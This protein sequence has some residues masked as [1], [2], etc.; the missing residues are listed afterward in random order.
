MIITPSSQIVG[1]RIVETLGLVRGNT[2]RA[3][4]LGKD[5]LAGL[6]NLVG[7]EIEEYTK[8]MAES[9]EQA[10]DRMIAH[11]AELGANAI[12]DVRFSTSYVMGS[13]AEILVFG[14]AVAVEPE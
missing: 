8:M 4:H 1:Y 5:I 9:R 13:A 2:I 14:T 3:R 12:V 6:K 10:I 11:A 7:G